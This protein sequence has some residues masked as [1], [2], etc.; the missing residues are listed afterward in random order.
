[1][2]IILGTVFEKKCETIKCGSKKKFVKLET[3]I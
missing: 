3:S 1:M 2:S